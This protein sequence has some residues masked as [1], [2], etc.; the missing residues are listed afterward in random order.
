MTLDTLSPMK[1]SWFSLLPPSLRVRLEEQKG[2][3]KIIGNILW[4][5]FDYALRLGFSFVVLAWLAR[6][7]GPKDFGIYSYALAFITL[8]ASFAALGLNNIVVRDLVRY[9][10]QRCAIMGSAWALRFTGGVIAIGLAAVLIALLK[11]GDDDRTLR[12]MV[13]IISLGFLL[14]PLDVID[15][16]FQS[17]VQSRN[18]VIA[19]NAAALLANIARI[20]LIVCNAPL[21]AFAWIMLLGVAA[22]QAALAVAYRLTGNFLTHWRAGLVTA[23]RLLADSWPLIFF[24]LA[25]AVYMRIDQVMIGQLLD[26][27]SVGI[28]AASVRL[29]SLWYFIPSAIVPS[30][31]PAIVRARE[32]DMRIYQSRLQLLYDLLALVCIGVAAVVALFPAPIVRLVYGAEYSKAAPVLA[33]HVWTSLFVSLSA[34]SQKF[35][36]TENLAKVASCRALLGCAVNVALNALLIPCMGIR[37]AAVA[38]LVSYSTATFAIAFHPSGRGQAAMMLRSICLVSVFLYVRRHFLDRS[39][40]DTRQ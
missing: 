29:S 16:W 31:F 13:V 27:E 9:P 18:T 30:V 5:V 23:R 19:R 35:L 24:G 3:Q 14:R 11:P 22:E 4:L 8:V 12:A 40:S 6:H 26:T 7:L 28:Y 38:T 10:E 36:L 17:Q 32:V 15:L 25:V 2:L 21:V 33:L 34:A 1:F 37:G 20:A 39:R